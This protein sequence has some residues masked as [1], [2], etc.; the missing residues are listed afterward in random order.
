MSVCS[1][2]PCLLLDDQA[3]AGAKSAIRVTGFFRIKQAIGKTVRFG[4]EVRD[5]PPNGIEKSK[6]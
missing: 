3:A 2:A 6:H 4:R 5:L 1:G